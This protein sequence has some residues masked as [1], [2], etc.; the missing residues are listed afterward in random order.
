VSFALQRA[1][2][3]GAGDVK[4][5]TAAAAA[6]AAQIDRVMHAVARA[7]GSPALDVSASLQAALMTT[8]ADSAAGSHDGAT[9]SH[10]ALLLQLVGHAPDDSNGGGDGG[11]GAPCCVSFTNDVDMAMVLETLDPAYGS[12]GVGG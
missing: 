6:R 4:A 1:V 8:P 3:K 9:G 10:G 7:L 5:A 11:G 2:A 12:L